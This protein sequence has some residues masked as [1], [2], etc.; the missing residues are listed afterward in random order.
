MPAGVTRDPVTVGGDCGVGA[1]GVS[2]DNGPQPERRQLLRWPF[3]ID[4][5][6]APPA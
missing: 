6:V 1:A 2:T 4:T 5:D 3:A